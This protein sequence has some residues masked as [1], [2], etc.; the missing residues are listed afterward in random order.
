MK[1]NRLTSN[2]PLIF[3]LGLVLAA[4]TCRTVEVSLPPKE[5]TILLKGNLSAID[6]V[7]LSPD[8]QIQKGAPSGQYSIKTPTMDGG[9]SEFAFLI[10]YNKHEPMQ[11]KIISVRKNKAAV[12][13]FSMA[14]LY[15]LPRIGDAHVLRID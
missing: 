1:H 14:D 13:D 5:I 10:R 2:F 12:A 7:P 11:Y 3:V 9:Y 6:I 15:A 4:P 8:I